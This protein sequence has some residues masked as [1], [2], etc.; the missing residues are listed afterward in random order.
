MEGREFGI[1]GC[2]IFWF[3]NVRIG[4]ISSAPITECS[5]TIGKTA[6]GAAVFIDYGERL[7]TILWPNGDYVVLCICGTYTIPDC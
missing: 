7:L 1:K 2:G 6:E 3:R 4:N 5:E